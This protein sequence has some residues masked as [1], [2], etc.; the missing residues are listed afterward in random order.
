[1]PTDVPARRAEI[2]AHEFDSRT[3]RRTDC[4]AERSA[5]GLRDLRQRRF[6]EIFGG[7]QDVSGNSESPG[8]LPRKASDALGA[9]AS[10]MLRIAASERLAQAPPPGTVRRSF[11]L[12]QRTGCFTAN[13]MR[14]SP[15]PCVLRQD[16][17]V[18]ARKLAAPPIASIAGDAP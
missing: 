6:A 11:A 17:P 4:Q 18:R 13:A 14:S 9:M 5:D 10:A 3:F 8:R 15:P 16:Q 2:A 12:V 7:A 1:M